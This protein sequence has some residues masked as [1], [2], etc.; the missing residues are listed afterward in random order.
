MQ[1]TRRNWLR[2]ASAAVAGVA[3]AGC[4]AL[5]TDES[6]ESEPETEPSSTAPET[7]QEAQEGQEEELEASAVDIG[8]VSEWNAIRTRLRDPV[9]LGHAEEYAAGVSV[10]GDIFERF[11]SAAG[12]HNA[13]ETLEETSEESYEGFEGALGD[14]RETLEA[15]ELDGA[16]DAMK[17]ADKHLRQAQAALTDEQTVKQLSMLVMGTHAEDAAMLV[18]LEDYDDA[19]HE[20]THIGDKFEEKHYE[21]VAAAD[22][23]AADQFVDAMDRAAENTESDSGAAMEAADEAFGAATQG[24]HALAGDAVAG[25]GHMAA[26][27]ARGWDGAT[28]AQLGGPL[29]SY[30]HAAALNDYRALARDIQWLYEDGSEAAAGAFVQRALERF[31]TARAHD[32]LEEADHDAYESFEGGLETLGE[33]IETGD[34]AGV[35]EAVESV[36]EGVRNGITSLAAGTQPA[37]LEAGYT[38]ARIEDAH[39]RYLRGESERAAEIAQAV[40]ADFEADAGG[41]HETLEETD[42]GLYEAFEHEHLEALIEAF[43]NEND[44]AVTTHVEGIRATLLDFETAAGSRAAVSGVE[45]GYITARLRDAV[46]LDQLGSTERGQTV[47]TEAFG[48]FEG[49]AGGFHEA[50][51][52]A[53]HETYE[54]FEGAVETLQNSLGNDGATG[55]LET[56][57][58][59]ATDATYAVVA[60]GSGGSGAV[61]LV[62]AIFEHFETAAVHDMLEEADH[63]SYEGFESALDSYIDALEA[64]GDAQGAADTYAD[65]S[66]QAQFAVAGAPEEAPVDVAGGGHDEEASEETELEGGPNVVEGVPEGADHVV[67]M[68]PV[69]F[70]PEELTVSQGDTVAWTHAGGEPHSVTAYGEKIPDDADYWASGGF[71]DEAAAREGWENGTGAIQSGQSY[72]KTFETTGTHEYVCIPH[73]AAGMV[74]TVVVES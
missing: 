59:R 21:M 46:V 9:I 26:L 7:E 6:E 31:E 16:H 2:T 48:H 45:S 29:Q 25:A 22:K 52:E 8:V 42:E 54:S 13:H 32:A 64:G 39:E 55:A 43:Q 20:F 60:A 19:E 49:G 33:A 36:T 72:V 37:L 40:F 65:A 62:S 56:V 1:Q 51:E 61:P 57:T 5:S 38:K 47:A 30:A 50:I 12:E 73:E 17:R 24:L 28:L 14:L 4:S 10:V 35:G 71:D 27:Q 58:A 69:S 70:D 44:D 74:G 53:D 3:L 34:D 63:E 18:A 15:E 67:D 11:E 23:A 66:L 41:F 68:N